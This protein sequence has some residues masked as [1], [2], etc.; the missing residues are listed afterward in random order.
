MGVRE[1]IDRQKR[2]MIPAVVVGIGAC[3]V[4][5]WHSYHENDL[6]GMVERA[7]YSDDDGQSYFAEDVAKGYSFDHGGKQA[8]RVFVYRCGSGK[9]FVGVLVRPAGQAPAPTASNLRYKGQ[10]GPP[11]ALEVRKPGQT[12]W[13][14]TGTGE[15]LNLLKSLCP[16]GNPEAV[17][18]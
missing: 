13:V 17:L 5:A 14:L 2:W 16:D 10:A 8:S 7:Y 4:S 6:P 18:P 3:A 12:K 15:G 11:P 9:P 1:L